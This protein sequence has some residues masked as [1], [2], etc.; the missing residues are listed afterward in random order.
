MLQTFVARADHSKWQKKSTD[1]K[2]EIESKQ[3]R[4]VGIS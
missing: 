3:N 4:P 1:R 2:T